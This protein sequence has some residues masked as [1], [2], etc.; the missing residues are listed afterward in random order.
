[1]VSSSS[2]QL[3]IVLLLVLARTTAG[4]KLIANGEGIDCIRGSNL[5]GTLFPLRIIG[6]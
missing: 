6:P 5:L 3:C 1:M 4:L 2:A